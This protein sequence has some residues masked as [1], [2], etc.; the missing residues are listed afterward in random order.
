MVHESSERQQTPASDGGTSPAGRA[1]STPPRIPLLKQAGPPPLPAGPAAAAPVDGGKTGPIEASD[2]AREKSDPTHVAGPAEVAKSDPAGPPPPPPSHGQSARREPVPLKV[3]Q[4]KATT[5]P[6]AGEPPAAE[7]AAGAGEPPAQVEPDAA[8]A[9]RRSAQRRPA[10]PPR[11]TIAANDDVPSI[12]GLIYALQQKPSQRPMTVAAIASGVWALLGLLLGWA[13]LA[14]ELQRAPTLLEMLSRPTAMTLAATILIPIALFWFLALL[15]WRAQEL[16]LMS[17]AMTEVAIRL[18]E[19]DR[20][21]EQQIASVG[22]AVRRQVSFMNEAVSRALGRAGELEALVHSEV[23]ALERAYSENE[24]RIRGLLHELSGE[25]H[26]LLNTSERVNQALKDMGTQI[27]ALVDRLGQQQI[28]LAGFI[29]G[30]GRNLNDLET[31]LTT[32]AERVSGLLGDQSAKIEGVFGQLTHS[33]SEGLTNRIEDL[34]STVEQQV[35]SLDVTLA[36]RA[37]GLQLALDHHARS[38]DASLTGRAESLQIAF[39]QQAK[40]LDESLAH[41]TEGLQ[42][43]FEEYARALD[44]TLANRQQALDGQLTERVRALDDAF[45]DRLRLFDETVLR[46]TLAIDSSIA[47]KAKSLTG[48][49]DG[50]VREISSV[51]GHQAERIDDQLMAGVNA[52]RTASENV[53]RQSMAAIEGLATQTEMLRNVSENLLG[54]ISSVT[55][56]FETQGQTIMQAANALESANV[57]I[58]KTLQVRQSELTQKLAQ[59]ADKSGEIDKTLRGYSTS[60]E[61]SLTEAENRARLV[62]EQLT[63]GA[64]ERSRQTLSEL[65]RLR[66][67]TDTEADRA[68][69][70]LKA[71]F[72]TVSQ[73]VSEQI[74]SLT[75]RFHS[76]SEEMR[77]RARVAL[78]ELEGEHSRLREQLDSLPAATQASAEAMRQ[79]LQD[80]LRA[81]QQLSSL[82]SRETSR[83]D[84]TPPAQLMPPPRPTAPPVPPSGIVADATSR[85]RPHAAQA[86]PAA[87]PP[88][89]REGWSLGDLLARASEDEGGRGGAEGAGLNIQGIARALDATTASAI[90]ARF[91][92]GQ[93]GIMVRSIYTVEGRAIFDEIQRR[94]R[95]EAGFR[96]TV[97]RFLLDFEQVLREA[98]Q[99]DG[100]GRT[101]QSYVVSDGGR[102]YLFLAHASGRLA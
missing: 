31:S 7:A 42:T 65:D 59:I 99:Q 63:R 41:R 29:E 102:V 72:S 91:R 12:G 51:L 33:L 6:A 8:Q 1:E 11:A 50:H 37:E 34:K 43:V 56:R 14:P 89:G 17:S 96:G 52:V 49:L 19:P 4:L 18:A 78:K 13:M 90:W 94:Y 20:M 46:S 47:D 25:R 54:R 62:A 95:T 77:Q 70:D 16:R 2:P 86:A 84:V 22:Q 79:S 74:G 38:V 60:L 61:G 80:Q 76:T 100:S 83:R 92:T 69:A 27:P 97:D 10:G 26:A 66:A 40:A 58:D 53:T 67:T 85:S 71:K 36:T 24:H 35:R 93:R 73:E 45:S 82:T 23:A 68:L 44:V 101:V 30:A 81:L 57:R 64:E 5:S 9:G 87:A 21:A 28:R 75:S 39:E 3:Q 32:S 48:A 15:V 88:S 98:D 55:N